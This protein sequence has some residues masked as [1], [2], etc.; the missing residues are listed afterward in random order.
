MTAFATVFIHIISIYL[1]N[2]PYWDM[3]FIFEVLFIALIFYYR[4]K[5]N[6]VIWDGVYWI[7][8]GLPLTLLSYYIFIPELQGTILLFQLTILVFNGLINVLIA[9]IILSY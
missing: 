1:F 7:I 6:M 8:I 2:T 9:D 4:K 3:L 5:G